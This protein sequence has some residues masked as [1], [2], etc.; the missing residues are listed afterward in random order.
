M[1]T[2]EKSLTSSLQ[3]RRVLV[4]RAAEQALDTVALLRQCGAEVLECPTIQL[5]PPNQWE[6]VD[7]AIRRLPEF[8]WLILTSLNGVRF[9]LGRVQE[10][11]IELS[12]LRSCKICAVGSKTAQFLGTYG[13]E[14]DLIP[15]QFTGEGIVGAF[16]GIELQGVRIL[17][18]KA[19]GARDLIPQKLRESGAIVVDPVVYQNV[20]PEQLP[21]AAR[22][23]LQHHV[24][25]AVIFSSP[26]TV[27][28]FAQLV[29]DETDLHQ[30]LSGV[31]V[32]SIGPIT[33][34][35][36]REL[37]LVVT[38][39]PAQATMENLIASLAAFFVNNK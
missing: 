11:G 12:Q 16:G 21:E 6:P 24:L 37:G 1:C 18:P 29:D 20:M 23:A 14:P 17:F 36:V 35:A 3:G 5:L 31:V 9:F 4:T 30:L 34:Q 22:I 33:T 13:L 28:N 7:N 10:L 26:S 32:A 15:E 27:R 19:D 2:N 8:N 38:V 25:D 39:E